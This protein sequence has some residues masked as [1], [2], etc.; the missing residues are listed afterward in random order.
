VIARRSRREGRI[1]TVFAGAEGQTGLLY[2]PRS[3]RE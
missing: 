3:G 2:H 1:E